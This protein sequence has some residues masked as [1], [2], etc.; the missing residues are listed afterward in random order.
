MTLVEVLMA[1]AILVVGMIVIFAILNAGFRAH[2][3]AIN[4]TEASLVA[5]SV[6]SELR[7]EFFRGRTPR[8]DPPD[9]WHESSDYPRYKYRKVI[10]PLETARRG[11][12]EAAADREFFVRVL[13][14]WSELGENKSISVDTIMYCNRK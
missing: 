13:V 12:D 1:F 5:A 3:R 11:L 6:T 4:E 7:A 2:K 10:V 14:R 8:S 9:A